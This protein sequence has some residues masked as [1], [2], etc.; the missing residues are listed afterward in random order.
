MVRLHATAR[1][2]FA[3]INQVTTPLY[4]ADLQNWKLIRAPK[5]W[6]KWKKYERCLV[7]IHY[8]HELIYQPLQH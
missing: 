8:L 3:A 6:Y 2:S 5:Q 1:F 7:W 4:V